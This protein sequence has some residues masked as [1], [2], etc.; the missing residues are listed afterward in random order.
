MESVAHDN[1]RA[2]GCIKL[3]SILEVFWQWGPPLI[4]V[5]K[6]ATRMQCS[7]NGTIT[8]KNKLYG[9]G[10]PVLNG[11][12]DEGAEGEE[13]RGGVVLVRCRLAAKDLEFVCHALTT[14]RGQVGNG[15]N[16]IKIKSWSTKSL[17]IPRKGKNTPDKNLM[18]ICFQEGLMI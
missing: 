9:D 2:F 3:T 7:A 4:F 18:E 17:C 8:F 1:C 10:L 5:A 6:K 15:T 12:T 13:G 16:Q 11:M 14:T